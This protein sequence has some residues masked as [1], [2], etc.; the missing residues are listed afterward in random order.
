MHW[1]T[2]LRLRARGQ[3]AD[4]LCNNFALQELNRLNWF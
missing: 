4:S 3:A 2:Y 1:R